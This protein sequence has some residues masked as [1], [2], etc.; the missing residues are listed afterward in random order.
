MDFIDHMIGSHLI[1]QIQNL[2]YPKKEV[3]RFDTSSEA[4]KDLKKQ[5]DEDFLINIFSLFNAL[6]A[7]DESK[8]DKSTPPQ[9]KE[10]KQYITL[11]SMSRNLPKVFGIKNDFFARMLFEHMSNHS[12]TSHIVNYFQFFESFM[13]IWPKKEIVTDTETPAQREFRQG[14]EK[15]ARNEALRRFIYDF[16]RISGDRQLNILDLIQMCAHFD[17]ETVLGGE[18][19]ALLDN[20][21]DKMRNSRVKIPM[22]FNYANFIKLTTDP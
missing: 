21:F 3:E 6:G 18:V 10:A 14:N 9:E 13:V 17:R 12:P 16:M 7:V 2:L 5:V 1:E 15:K 19:H 4:F 22:Q 11:E 8:F 20:I